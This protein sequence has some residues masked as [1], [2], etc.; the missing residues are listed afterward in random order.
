MCV[1]LRAKTYEMCTLEFIE[2]IA[3]ICFDRTKSSWT[4]G[5]EQSP[6]EWLISIKLNVFEPLTLIDAQTPPDYPF[7]W[8]TVNHSFILS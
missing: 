5:I 8:H 6:I 4:I 1:E 3:C 2:K 7:T